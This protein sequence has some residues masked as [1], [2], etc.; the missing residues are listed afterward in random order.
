MEKNERLSAALLRA[1][2][3]AAKIDANAKRT[4]FTT[5]TATAANA[6]RYAETTRKPK[7]A[8]VRVEADVL[9]LV[10]ALPTSDRVHRISEAIRKALKSS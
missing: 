9:E 8:T 1:S 3:R 2:A 5:A 6:K 7:T 4:R 10:K